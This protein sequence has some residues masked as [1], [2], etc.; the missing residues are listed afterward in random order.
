MVLEYHPNQD[1]GQI[2]FI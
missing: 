2:S 1:T